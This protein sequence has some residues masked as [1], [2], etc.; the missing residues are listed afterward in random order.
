MEIA[1]ATKALATAFIVLTASQPIKMPQT[2]QDATKVEQSLSWAIGVAENC[3]IRD[4]EWATEMMGNEL[5][6][7]KDWAIYFYPQ[8][9]AGNKDKATSALTIGIK[10]IERSYGDGLFLDYPPCKT[11][12]EMGVIEKIEQQATEKPPPAPIAA[13]TYVLPTQ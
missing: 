6:A 4:H 11:M 7:E 12:L 13:P 10:G 5:G 2:F 8:T 1:I 3:Q 9:I